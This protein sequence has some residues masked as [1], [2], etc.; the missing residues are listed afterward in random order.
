MKRQFSRM[1]LRIEMYREGM[2]DSPYNIYIKQREVNRP[3]ERERE[4]K[5]PLAYSFA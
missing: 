1:W 4:K 2:R 3:R 5:E